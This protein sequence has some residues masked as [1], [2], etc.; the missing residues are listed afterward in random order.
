MTS[1]AGIW[2]VVLVSLLIATPATGQGS[3]VAEHLFREG[4]RLMLEGKITEACT[5]FEGS[6]ARDPAISTLLN[7]ADCREKNGQYAS[8]WGHFIDA[9][10]MARRDPASRALGVTA[11]T[12]A[13]ALENKL[14]FLIIN[15]A[16]EAQVE[17]LQITRNG[18]VVD[19]AEWNT[20][21]PVDPGRYI[22]EGKAPGYEPWRTDVVVGKGHDK[23][24]VNVPR[25]RTRPTAPT[26]TPTRAETN[27]RDQQPHTRRQALIAA[28]A[29]GSALV[30]T[31]A[32]LGYLASQKWKDAEALCGTDHVCD[33]EGDRVAGNKLVDGARLRGNV[34][35]VAGA[36]GVVALGAG[37]YLWLTEPPRTGDRRTSASW[38]AAPSVSPDGF[39]VFIV[40]EL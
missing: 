14:S 13:E 8:A 12:R 7:L 23:Q 6:Y 11:K 39:A 9:E 17:G 40:G 36:L 29:G 19:N 18:E 22:V 5:A 10:R 4:K 28:V 16:D 24:S 1:K 33:S 21:I 31:S 2:V 35:T 20:D 26:P 37:V 3:G 30:V 15:V 38:R 34:A 32:S 25:F 27:H